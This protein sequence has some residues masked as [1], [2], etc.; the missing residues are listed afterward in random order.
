V[1]SHRALRPGN[2]KENK[3]EDFP[4]W[5]KLF[6]YAIIDGAAIHVLGAFVYQTHS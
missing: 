2:P 6:L 1:E 5:M 3:M 4:V